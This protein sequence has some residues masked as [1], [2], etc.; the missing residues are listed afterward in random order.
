MT[1]PSFAVRG[2]CAVLAAALSSSL[3]A[4]AYQAPR[5]GSPRLPLVVLEPVVVVPSA[6]AWADLLRPPTA[7][8]AVHR[9]DAAEPCAP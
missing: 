5:G 7:V 3:V 6:D 4:L 8:A 1:G 2:G 9:C